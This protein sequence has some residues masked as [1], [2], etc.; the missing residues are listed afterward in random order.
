MESGNKQEREPPKV[1]VVAPSTRP[2]EAPFTDPATGLLIHGKP[3]AQ[4]QVQPSGKA[5]G[6]TKALDPAD[7]VDLFERKESRLPDLAEEAEE[8]VQG[9]R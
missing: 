4:G 5:T 3:S 6:P 9:P 1:V 7:I 2:P 8:A